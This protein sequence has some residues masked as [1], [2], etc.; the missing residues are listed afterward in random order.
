[1]PEPPTPE[2]PAVEA[3]MSEPPAVEATTPPARVTRAKDLK[4][5]TAGHKGAAARKAKQEAVLEQFRKAKDGLRA[6]PQ[7]HHAPAAVEAPTP[8]ATVVEATSNLWPYAVF[9]GAAALALFAVM[10]C[11]P[12]PAFSGANYGFSLLGGGSSGADEERKRHDTAVEQLEAAQTAWSHKRTERLDWIN[13]DLRH[14]GHAVRTFRN[15]EEAIRQYNLISGPLEEMAPE[16]KLS[17]F[18]LPSPEQRDREIAFV[19][20]V[21]ML[22]E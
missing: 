9:A 11:P 14:Q 7:E 4:K 19:V 20:I 5:V 12:I 16:P 8:P 13:E 18:Y 15:V 6:D 1:M 2:P 3:T 21:Y 17:D 22:A 10:P